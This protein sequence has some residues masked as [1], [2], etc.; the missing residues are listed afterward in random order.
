[1]INLRPFSLP[2]ILGAMKGVAMMSPENNQ[3]NFKKGAAPLAIL[4]LLKKEDMYG[5]QLAQA[6]AEASGGD[7]LLQEGTLYPILYR[8]ADGG[9]ISE[10]RVLVGK[11]MTRVYYHLEEAGLA[12][13]QS[14]L[15][16]YRSIQRGMDRILADG[17]DA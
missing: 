1:M 8:L 11:R 15:N 5:Y 14:L 10:K 7:F 2:E 9:Y 17:K 3:F 16:D 12:Y 4:S 6:V 13:Y